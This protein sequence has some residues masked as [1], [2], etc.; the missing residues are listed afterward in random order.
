MEPTRQWAMQLPRLQG[1]VLPG[2]WVNTL[3]S[4]SPD[5][6]TD[7]EALFWR[8]SPMGRNRQVPHVSAGHKQGVHEQERFTS[9]QPLSSPGIILG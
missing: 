4:S 3:A 5:G 7:K 2:E 1:H 8:P 6:K 9:T